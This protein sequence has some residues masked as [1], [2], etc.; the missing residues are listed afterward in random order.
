MNKDDQV[1]EPRR[2]KRPAA[3]VAKLKIQDKIE[4]EQGIP[5]VE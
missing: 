2:S 4:D 1:Q 5:L 3:A